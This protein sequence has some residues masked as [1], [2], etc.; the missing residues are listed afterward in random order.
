[1]D[2]GKIQ[3][4]DLRNNIL[5]HSEKELMVMKIYLINESEQ[6]FNNIKSWSINDTVNINDI[7][8]ELQMILI[9]SKIWK[10]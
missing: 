2:L 3:I 1:M 4:N 6:E 8:D 10:K 7:N 5:D 9:K